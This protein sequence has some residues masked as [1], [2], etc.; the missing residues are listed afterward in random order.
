MKYDITHTTTY[1]YRDAVSLS[2]HVLR[3]TPRNLRHQRCLS[4]DAHVDPIPAVSKPHY[5]YFGNAVSFVTVEGSHRRL[6]VRSSSRVSVTHSPLPVPAETPAWETV[7][8]SGRGEQIGPAL[9]A[10]EFMFDSPLVKPRDDFAD[11]ARPSFPKD[12]PSLDAVLDLTS[13]IHCDFKFDPK[14]TTIATPLEDVFKRRRGV[15]QD[16]AQFQI[17]CLRSLGLPA[18]YVSGYLE[19]DPPPGQPRLAGADASHAWVSF[20][21]HGIGWIDV[22]PTNN[23]LPATRHITLAWGRDFSDVSPLHGVILGSGEHTLKVAV[24]VVQA[25]EEAE[26]R[27]VKTIYTV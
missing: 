19:T 26:E 3:L 1:D 10:S 2:H 25:P 16:F 6:V 23:L 9:E 8:E 27:S 14:A 22:D 12:R 17:A 21:C 24:D 20:Y 5:D 7:R 11:Y 18:R 15:C 4:H 13:R